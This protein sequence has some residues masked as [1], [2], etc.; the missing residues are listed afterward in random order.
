MGDRQPFAT[1]TSTQAGAPAA[2]TGGGV[3]ELDGDG[4]HDGDGL[5]DGCAT[6]VEPQAAISATNGAASQA[7]RFTG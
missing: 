2:T 7:Q 3:G 6:G 4:D 5:G 1:L